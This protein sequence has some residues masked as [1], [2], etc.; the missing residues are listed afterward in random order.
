MKIDLSRKLMDVEG[1]EAKD[2][3]GKPLTLFRICSISLFAGLRDQSETDIGKLDK[4]W[5]LRTRLLE[6]EPVELKAEDITLLKERI[7]KIYSAPG[8][9]GQARM[10]LDQEFKKEEGKANA[11]IPTS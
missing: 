1:G 2:E 4:C 8:V 3:N 9:A 10:M 5:E 7:A 6:S 11:D